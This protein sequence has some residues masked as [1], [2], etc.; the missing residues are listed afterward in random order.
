M[1]FPFFAKR[2]ANQI[3]NSSPTVAT[4]NALQQIVLEKKI[5][6]LGS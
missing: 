3:Q 1:S 2:E 6:Q 5:A 4:Q